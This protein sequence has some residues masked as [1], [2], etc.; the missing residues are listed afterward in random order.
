M[1][2][3]KSKT[4]YI[5]AC[6]FLALGLLIGQVFVSTSVV[7][8]MLVAFLLL[9]VW[10]AFNGFALPILLF[11]LPWSPIMKIG[12]IN[13]SAYT[14]AL[15]AVALIYLMKCYKTI[16]IYH[17]IPG[18]VL[19][20]LTLV[21]RTFR[22][23]PFELGYISFI[24][25][26][27]FFPIIAKEL[28]EEHYGYFA[29][30]IFFSIGIIFAAISAQQLAAFPTM[31][32]FITVLSY[33]GLTRCAGFYGDPN[34]YS[35]HITTALAGLFVLFSNEKSKRNRT[36]IFLIAI[37]LVYCG[38]IGVSKMFVLVAAA[39]ILLWLLYTLFQKERLSMKMMLLLIFFVAVTFVSSST[40]FSDFIDQMIMRFTKE[41]GNLS[42]FTTNRSELWVAYFDA[43]VEDPMLLFFGRGFSSAVLPM[44]RAS[45]NTFIQIVYQ[46]G[47]VG[48]LAFVAWFVC[49]AKEAIVKVRLNYGKL[50][51]ILI[52]LMGAFG[53]CMALDFLFL[54]ELFMIPL[55]SAVG[56]MYISKTHDEELAQK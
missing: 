48:T 1:I 44:D 6:I 53:S 34:F 3:I 20:A 2:A 5:F 37:T 30:T 38:V 31:K 55:Y 46:F 7:T 26:L 8:L 45:H 56:I 15:F 36:V 18:L 39:V 12:S 42:N 17:L 9:V 27:M 33:S 16:K 29:L 14:V 43:F 21:V 19:I 52:L 24:V 11:F 23:I 35:A 47:L 32:R 4:L 13:T 25:F 40:I 22:G 28:E 41:T 54:D 49:Y 51:Q 10:S 50:F